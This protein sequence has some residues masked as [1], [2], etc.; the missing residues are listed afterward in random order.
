MPNYY[1]TEELA[2]IAGIFD[3]EGTVSLCISHRNDGKW[4]REIQIYEQL[5]ILNKKGIE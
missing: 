4:Y 5:K 2:Y 1:T 3:G